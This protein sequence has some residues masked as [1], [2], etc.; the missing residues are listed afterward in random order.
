MEQYVVISAA[1]FYLSHIHISM[2]YTHTARV[3]QAGH[4]SLVTER[5]WAKSEY[6]VK[7]TKRG[8]DLTLYYLPGRRSETT[9]GKGKGI[10]LVEDTRC[11]GL[12]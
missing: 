8:Y 11:V 5:T 1:C 6:P 2:A 9:A 12:T 3:S 7:S 10:R 4:V